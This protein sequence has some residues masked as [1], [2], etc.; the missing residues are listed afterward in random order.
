MKPLPVQL[1]QC[2]H[3]LSTVEN[4]RVTL[5]PPPFVM[6]QCGH[7]LSTVENFR[8]VQ[9]RQDGPLASMRPRPLDRGERAAPGRGGLETRRFNAATAS[10]PWRTTRTCTRTARGG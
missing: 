3:G 2:G 8:G 1:L 9:R 5:D 6:L 7:G 4:V 10:R